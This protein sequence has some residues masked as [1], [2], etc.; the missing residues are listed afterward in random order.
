[1]TC[2]PLDIK[3]LSGIY[4]NESIS[5]MA[6]RLF[7]SMGTINYRLKQL[8]TRTNIGQKNVLMQQLRKY[9][10]SVTAL[11]NMGQACSD[12]C[13]KALYNYEAEQVI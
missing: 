7:V 13:G 11:E 3:I 1:M 8:Y 10:S 5:S 6:Q 4:S 12:G 9:F 2:D